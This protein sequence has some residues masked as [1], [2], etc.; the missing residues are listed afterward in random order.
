MASKQKGV[1]G[2]SVRSTVASAHGAEDI[3]IGV[4]TRVF[5]NTALEVQLVVPA[6][7]LRCCRCERR[8][9][10]G[11]P[12]VRAL[13][14]QYRHEYWYAHTRC[15]AEYMLKHVDTVVQDLGFQARRWSRFG[16]KVGLKSRES[17]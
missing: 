17:R 2:A 7:A 8:V 12:V 10:A 1:T 13:G 15:V 9:R 16:S 3:R 4:P 11:T 5:G 6:F 14:G